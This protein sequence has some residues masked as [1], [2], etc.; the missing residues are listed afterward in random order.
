MKRR[1]VLLVS[2]RVSA[3]R[4]ADAIYVLEDGAIV[5]HG[6]HDELLSQSGHYAELQ[7][8]QRIEEELEAS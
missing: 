3:V 1:T 8:M 6:T 4:E 7:R 5:E 2:H